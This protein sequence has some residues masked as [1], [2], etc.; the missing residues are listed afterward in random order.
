MGT[1][2]SLVPGSPWTPMPT[3][4]RPS[5]TVN[6]GLSAPGRVH[7]EKATPNERV[8]SLACEATRCTSSSESPGVGGGGGD[9]EDR[10]VAGD[11]ASLVDLVGGGAGDVVG[12][13]ERDSSECRC[14]SSRF[15]RLTEVQHVTGVVAEAQQH[16]GP[17]GSAALATEH[18]CRA[19]GEAKRLPIAAP[20]AMPGPTRPAKAG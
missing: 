8:R 3:A 2:V 6:S 15:R 16:A 11:A 12:D 18:T 17:A 9:F 4:I 13:G 7:P 14:R 20:S 19:D 1:S 5:G 10:Q